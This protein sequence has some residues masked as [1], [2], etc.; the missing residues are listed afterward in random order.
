[1]AN[2][3]KP[4]VEVLYFEGCP[5]HEAAHALVERVAAELRLEAEIADVE[6]PDADAATRARF[7]GPP[8]GG[9]SGPAP[10]P[11][12]TERTEYVCACRVYRG[13][14]AFSGL[15]DGRWIRSALEEATS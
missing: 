5:N 15:P 7:L 13:A 10:P 11:G 2:V 9:G 3:L 6:V 12:A 14:R 4:L 1:M 8:T